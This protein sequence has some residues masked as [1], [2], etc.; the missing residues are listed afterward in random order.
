MNY[1]D[2][3]IEVIDML[4]H[5]HRVKVELKGMIPEFVS[6]EQYNF[7]C[8]DVGSM[9]LEANVIYSMGLEYPDD[10][11]IEERMRLDVLFVDDAIER[12]GCSNC[13]LY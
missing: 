11:T 5:P 13:E 6:E 2:S 9:Y 3:V 4:P 12:Y 8:A 10:S 7:M 1:K